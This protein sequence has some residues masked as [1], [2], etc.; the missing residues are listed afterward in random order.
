MQEATHTARRSE[1]STDAAIPSPAL[2]KVEHPE[3]GC[4]EHPEHPEHAEHPGSGACAPRAEDAN[5]R[6]EVLSRT[7]VWTVREASF[8][9]RCDESTIRRELNRG[10]IAGV[11]IG[12]KWRIPSAQFRALV[13]SPP[14]DAGTPVCRVCGGG[15]SGGSHADAAVPQDIAPAISYNLTRWHVSEMPSPS[16][17]H[18]SH[19]SHSSHSSHQA[20]PNNGTGQV[21]ANQ[22]CSAR[23]I[24][25]EPDP[26]RP[27]QAAVYLLGP[28]MLYI[29]SKRVEDL[30]RSSRRSQLVHLLALHRTGISGAL[31]ASLLSAQGHRYEDECLN[32]HYVRNLVW[33]VRDLARKA[34]GW[35]GL[36]QSPSRAG[37]GLH[38]YRL[39]D[40]TYCD[41]WDFEDKLAEADRLSSLA[42]PGTG[43]HTGRIL[44]LPALSRSYIEG[45]PPA[46]STPAPGI[47]APTLPAPKCEGTQYIRSNG[48]GPESGEQA[49]PAAH[50]RAAALREEA[51]RLYKGSLCT[52]SNNGFVAQAARELEERYVRAAMQQAGY[53]RATAAHSA[54]HPVG[55]RAVLRPLHLLP[56]PYADRDAALAT[57]QARG[58]ASHLSCPEVEAMW[59]ESARNYERVLAVDSYHEEAYMHLME[60]QAHLG[61]ARAVEQTYARCVDVLRADLSQAPGA[62]VVAMHRRCLDILRAPVFTGGAE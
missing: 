39:A 54:E 23:L 25:R 28:P 58:V 7:P 48:R 2:F 45:D 3:P 8:M 52:G 22:A 30:E 1:R 24:L 47:P 50:E 20:R 11:R 31:L 51:L 37:S 46:R 49:P 62:P 12:T 16:T 26:R 55:S 4:L 15:L 36:V 29:D 43:Q 57:G 61:N 13:S 17:A 19:S 32:P 33:A 56:A 9:L 40:G 34:S 42:S 21:E 5:S 6:L 53:W 60:C 14:E 27:H 41:L 18:P 35:G 38:H 44:H 10:S 59:R